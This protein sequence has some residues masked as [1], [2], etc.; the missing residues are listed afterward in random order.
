MIIILE[1]ADGVGKT[2]LAKQL[3][4]ELNFYTIHMDKPKNVTKAKQQKQWYKEILTTRNDVIL[5][6]SFYSQMIY[7]MIQ[8]DKSVYTM[9]DMLDLERDLSAANGIVIYVE[10]TMENIEEVFK[11]RGDDNVDIDDI[12]VIIQNYRALFSM[13]HKVPIF[14]YH[15]THSP[16]ED[17]MSI[18]NAIND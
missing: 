8:G 6:R 7:P 15:T 11:T 9:T 3:A 2:T 18:I 5:D 16:F 1:G 12:D 13:T 17:L 14:N 10:D 4:E